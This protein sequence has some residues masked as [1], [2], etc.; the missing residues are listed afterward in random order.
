[1]NALA[2][3]L[4]G[5]CYAESRLL[6]FRW[7]EFST[8]WG[9][10]LAL[11]KFEEH[12]SLHAHL[13]YINI[14]ISLWRPRKEP[15]GGM[16]SYGFSIPWDMGIG[17]LSAVHFNWG[18]K[19]KI[20]EMPW[21]WKFYRH[22][23]LAEDGKNWIHELASHRGKEVIALP[24]KSDKCYFFNDLP[25]WS[26]E[27]PYRYVLNS[28]EVQERTATIRVSEREWRRRWLMWLAWPRK[29]KR[30]LDVEFSDEVGE[31][32]G[33]WK[34]G[35]TGCSYELRETELPWD[36]LRRMEQERKFN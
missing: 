31:R 24:P 30:S 13:I 29:V 22:S 16:E 33:S 27:A 21:A 19:S 1:M 18:D 9:L 7:G 35:C 26:Y 17:K 5:F 10:A 2:R 6:K 15:E 8:G 28:G 20:I 34:G 25:H 32:T 36:C 14:F 4:T 12:W 3:R 23:I 11:C